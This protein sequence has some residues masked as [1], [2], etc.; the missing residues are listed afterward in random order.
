M[1]KFLPESNAIIGSGIAMIHGAYTKQ[2]KCS[3]AVNPR[4]GKFNW[5]ITFLQQKV[6]SWDCKQCRNK[7]CK[8]INRFSYA[9]HQKLF[10]VFV[11][12]SWLFGNLIKKMI[13]LLNI[14]IR[15]IN[16]E[17]QFRHNPCLMANSGP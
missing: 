4:S 17:S 12:L 3:D 11:F 14:F 15:I 2:N 10:S 7:V 9:S 13:H 6:S 8:E 16:K 1:I 5:G